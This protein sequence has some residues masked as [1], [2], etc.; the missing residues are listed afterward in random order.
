MKYNI[1]NYDQKTAIDNKLDLKDLL[2]LNWIQ[3]FFH[4][5][6]IVKKIIDNKEYGWIK[7][8]YMMQQIPIIEMSMAG[9]N[10]IT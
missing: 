4:S 1:F 7:Y 8:D 3:D 5:D 10:M 9:S 2:I 6:S